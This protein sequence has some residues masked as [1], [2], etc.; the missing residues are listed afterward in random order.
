[1]RLCRMRTTGGN[2]SEKWRHKEPGAIFLKIRIFDLYS[3]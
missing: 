1:M 3:I 2:N